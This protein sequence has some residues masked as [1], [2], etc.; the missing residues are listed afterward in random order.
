MFNPLISQISKDLNI[1]QFKNEAIKSF[2]NRLIYSAISAW[3]RVLVLGKSYTD[4]HL[5]IETQYPNVDIN[6]IQNRA[7]QVAYGLLKSIPHEDS[8]LPGSMEDQCSELASTIIRLMKFCFEISQLYDSRR[9][10]TSP[11][12]FID[13]EN[14]RAHFGGVDWNNN[15]NS[16]HTV[17]LGRWELDSKSKRNN[18]L[19]FDIPNVNYE[20]FLSELISNILWKD[21][22]LNGDY[23]IFLTGLNRFNREAWK[24][25]D[26]PKIP[27]GISLLRNISDGGYLLVNRE[28]SSVMSVCLLDNWYYQEKELFRIMYALNCNA[29]TPIK[30]YTEH[31]EDHVILHTHSSLPNAETRLILMSSWPKRSFN[32]IYYR[33]IPK[34]MWPVIQPILENLGVRLVNQ[35]GLGG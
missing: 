29:L 18:Q 24:T 20:K 4:L 25:I 5:S 27:Q 31:K 19:I 34:F 30:F 13:I 7:S 3:I 23:E 35:I 11:K 28:N 12:R 17:G 26:T 8:W 2:G 9:L 14:M 32:D 10:T 1:Q 33:I 6:H 22:E 16:W 15:S 21:K